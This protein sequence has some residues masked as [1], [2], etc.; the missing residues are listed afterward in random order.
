MDYEKI[1]K[2]GERVEWYGVQVPQELLTNAVREWCDP[3]IH[4][5]HLLEGELSDLKGTEKEKRSNTIKTLWNKVKNA[6]YTLN[7]DVYLIKKKKYES[8]IVVVEKKE[9][10]T[11]KVKVKTTEVA[12]NTSLKKTKNSELIFGKKT[13]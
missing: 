11:K 10:R 1:I 12:K 4:Q 13:K 8:E 7:G 9:K 2:T 6:P 5:I 3:L